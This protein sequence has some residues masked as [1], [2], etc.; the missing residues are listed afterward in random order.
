MYRIFTNQSCH[1][2]NKY[3]IYKKNQYIQYI[4]IT[5]NSTLFTD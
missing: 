3:Q 2:V 1:E 5:T 4:L